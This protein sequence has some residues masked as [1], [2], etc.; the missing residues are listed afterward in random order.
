MKRSLPIVLF[1][2][3][4]SAGALAA[5][6]PQCRQQIVDKSVIEMC[7]V[8]GGAFEHDIY[9]L[10]ADKILIFALVDDYSEKVELEHTIPDGVSLEFP[11]STQGEKVVK[12]RGGCVPE[13]KD[14]VEIARLCNFYWGKYQVVKDI[15]F[16]FK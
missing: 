3:F 6:Q 10:R 12:I 4:V 9:T 1:S 8:P 14:G 13:N 15:R 2:F 16:V 11:L 7:V 5:G